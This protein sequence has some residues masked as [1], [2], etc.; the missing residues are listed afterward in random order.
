MPKVGI[1]FRLGLRLIMPEYVRLEGLGCR[2]RNPN[3][4]LVRR[5][6]DPL[7]W[8]GLLMCPDLALRLYFFTR[9]RSTNNI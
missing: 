5:D 4:G 7:Q 8:I 9:S 2:V 1:I 3:N 6:G